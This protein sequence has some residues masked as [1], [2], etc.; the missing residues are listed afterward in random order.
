MLVGGNYDDILAL[1]ISI[2]QNVAAALGRRVENLVVLEKEEKE[3]F[4]KHIKVIGSTV[5]T[6]PG[7]KRPSQRY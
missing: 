3:Q 1:P 2:S 7:A 5:L 4:I 6:L